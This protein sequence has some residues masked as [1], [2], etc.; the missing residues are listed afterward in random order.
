MSYGFGA[1]PS[2][3]LG[4]I[5]KR[6]I[7]SIGPARERA[8]TLSLR[9]G[10]MQVPLGAPAL[11]AF[12]SRRREPGDPSVPLGRT[13]VSLPEGSLP[14]SFSIDALSRRSLRC[15]HETRS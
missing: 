2:G 11:A 9:H 3:G 4:H 6:A 10:C 8:A 1:V 13:T 12:L 5:A 7:R 15:A 14:G